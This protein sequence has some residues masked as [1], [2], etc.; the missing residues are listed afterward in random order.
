MLG[1]MNIAGRF[2][3]E[4]ITQAPRSG[5]GV[6]ITVRLATVSDHT[7]PTRQRERSRVIET[8]ALALERDR[9]VA[10]ERRAGRPPLNGAVTAPRED[11]TRAPP[12]RRNQSR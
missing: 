11:Q 10:K 8:R 9:A 5:G 7:P 1:L 12:P 3:I 4:T 2:V 6:V